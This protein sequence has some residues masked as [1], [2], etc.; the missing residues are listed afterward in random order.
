[1]AL[2]P[3]AEIT[4]PEVRKIAEKLNLTIAKKKDSTG[5]CFIGERNFRQFLKNYIPAQPGKI[6]DIKSKKII[7]DH[8]GVYYYTIGQHRGL[9]I[10][11][12]HGFDNLP[13][14][15]VGK[16]VEKNIL[17]VGQ[18]HLVGKNGFLRNCLE[19]DVALSMILYGPSGCGKTTI[20]EAFAKSMNINFIKLNAVTS[21]KDEMMQA[22][23]EAKLIPSIIMV[24]EVHRLNK[25]KQD[26]FLPYLEAGTFIF[27]GAT[28]SNPIL[29]INKAIRSR[30]RLLEVLPL[31]PQ[32]ILIGLK[33]AL[34]SPNG[35]NNSRSFSDE[36]LN[37]ISKIAG[38]D[39]RYGYNILKT[40]ATVR[41]STYFY[42]D[43][44]DIKRLVGACKNGGNFLDAYFI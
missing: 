42:N 14:F 9:N 36:A 4:K 13:F 37:Y 32:E 20:A 28:T 8:D 15:V 25:D 27:I 12:Q 44:E 23:K 6:V 2:F 22:I 34:V 18:E 3:L 1:M 41:A 30:I 7:G 39:L 19:S 21:N 33:K 11:G 17:Y 40:S 26:L 35:L 10:G 24:D 16:D 31:K 38:G 5:V 43:E 29:A